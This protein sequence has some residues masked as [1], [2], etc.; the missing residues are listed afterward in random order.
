[1]VRSVSVQIAELLKDW[2]CAVKGSTRAEISGIEDD[3]RK[4]T[5]GALYIARRGQTYNGKNFL[6]EALEKGAAAI[7]I[8]DELLFDSVD[9]PVPLIWVPN[10]ESFIAYASAKMYG[11]PSD[12]LNIIAVTGTNGKTTVTHFIAQLLQQLKQQVIVIGTNGIYVNGEKQYEEI[13]NLTTLQAKDLQFICSEAIKKE[14]PYIVLEASSMGLLKHRLDY[15]KIQLGVFLN[16]TEDHIEQHGSFEKYK[17]AKEILAK[18][19]DKIVVN[20]D[21][22]MCRSIGLASKKKTIFFGKTNYVDYHWQLLTDSETQSSC[23]LQYRNEK[24]IVTFPLTGDYQCSNVIAAMSVVKELGF[25]LDEICQAVKKLTLP[26]GRFQRIENALG[27]M[28]Y[29]DYAHTPD[30]MKMLLQTIRKQAKSRVIVVFSC[31]GER[32]K[33]KRPKMGMIASTYADYIILTTDN[34]RSESPQQINEQIIQGFS[35]AQ[36]YEI[37]LD[38]KQAIEKALTLAKKDDTVVILG[39]GHEKTQQVGRKVDYFSD[40]QCVI[41]LLKQLELKM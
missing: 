16:I 41:Q 38:R 15:C 19:S 33:V 29:I 12:A 10:C 11:F 7:A 2:P 31:G 4:I 9:F 18:L 14:I 3:T 37:K 25:S 39:K 21:D 5:A 13:E 17:Q 30:A 26:E 20:R 35:S 40:Q 28:I 1:M 8:D 36:L 32:D 6:T 34:A 24:H 22:A 23:C 27:I